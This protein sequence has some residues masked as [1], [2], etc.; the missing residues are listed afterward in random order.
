[1]LVKSTF[2]YRGVILL[3]VN[4]VRGGKG[5]LLLFK[6]VFVFLGLPDSENH[7]K[8]RDENDIHSTVKQL[9]LVDIVIG[10]L[11][12][13]EDSRNCQDDETDSTQNVENGQFLNL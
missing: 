1:M 6:E 7:H 13:N 12:S 5:H 11:N 9:L 3:I 8:E 2:F 4:F 10:D